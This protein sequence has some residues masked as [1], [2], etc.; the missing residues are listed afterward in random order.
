[1]IFSRGKIRNRPA[2]DLG[3]SILDYTDEYSYLGVVFHYNGKFNKAR[4]CMFDKA[5]RA[6]FG[7]LSRSRTLNLPIDIQLQ[8]FDVL[9]A[10]IVLYGSE[11]WSYENCELIEK[12]HLR[13]CKFLLKV[14]DKT[15][16]NMVYG[17]LGRT[18]LLLTMQLR[19]IV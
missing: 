8:L 3:G 19:G 7:L 5:N 4:K 6:M 13:Y 11:I 17:E 18:P 10:P 14:N 9:F 15:Y 12:L 1:M 2:F 16:R